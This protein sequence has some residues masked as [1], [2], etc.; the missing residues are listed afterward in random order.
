MIPTFNIIDFGP[1]SKA[2]L[3][4]GINDFSNACLHVQSLPFA[5]IDN[6]IDFLS[7]LSE[8]KGTCSTKHALLATLALENGREDIELM[9][10]IYLIDEVTHPQLKT[11]FIEHGIIGVPENHAFLRCGQQRYDFSRSDWSIVDFEHRI[12]REQRCD[13]NQMHDWKPMIHKHYIGGWLKRQ[14]IDLTI[15]QIWAIR[16]KCVLQWMDF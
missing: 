7:V 3:A 12:V 15:D 11:V 5:R 8:G 14:Q 16:E 2:F 9:V 10:G 13:P 4:R 6:P 1:V